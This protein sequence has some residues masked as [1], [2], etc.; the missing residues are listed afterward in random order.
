M[1]PLTA[2]DEESVKV[3]AEALRMVAGALEDAVVLLRAGCPGSTWIP[4]FALIR[5]RLLREAGSQP[6]RAVEPPAERR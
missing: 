1:R 6:L 5:V 2:H 3:Q 4:A